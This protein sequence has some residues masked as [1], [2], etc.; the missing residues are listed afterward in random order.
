MNRVK[1]LVI[2]AASGIIEICLLLCGIC[3]H[4]DWRIAILFPV[5]VPAI[6]AIALRKN[7]YAEKLCLSL[8]S[9]VL[10]L[11]IQNIFAVFWGDDGT[12]LGMMLFSFI[13]T[14]IPFALYTLIITVLHFLKQ[15]QIKKAKN[16]L[17]S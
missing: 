16:N 4:H 12:L 14:C 8:A 5:L 13:F 6:I 9:M 2:I 15:K 1:Y 11:F 17:L 10:L 7:N 3:F